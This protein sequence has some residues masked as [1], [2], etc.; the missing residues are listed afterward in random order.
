[1]YRMVRVQ[2]EKILKNTGYALSRNPQVIQTLKDNH[3]DQSL[4]KQMLFLSKK[5]NL[6]YIVLINLKGIRFTHPDSTKI[7]KPFQGGD[8]QAVFKGKAIMSTAEGSLGK[9]LRY[10]IPVYDHQKQVGAIAVGLKLTTLGDLSQSSIK[11]F[12]KPL[13]ISILIS[14]V[15]TSI[16]SYGLKKQLHN[17]HPSD[18]FQHLEERNATLDQIQAAVFVIDQRH[19][20]KRNNPAASL[21][22]KKEGQRDLF[23]GKLLES[24]IPQLKQDHFSKKTEQVLHF[25]GQDYLLSISPITVKTQNRGYVVFLR[26]VT[27]TLFTLDQL[28][29]T[30]A[31][32][33]ALQAQTHQFM[34]QLHVIYGLADIEYH[35]ELKIYLKEL[36]EPQNEFLARLSMLV[37]EPRLASFIIGER[38]KFAEKHINLSTEI[39]VDIPTKSTVEDVNNYLLLHRYINTKILT[40]LNSTTLVSLRLNYQNNLI[41]TDYQWENEKWLLNDYHQYFNDAYFQQLL[42]DSRATYKISLKQDKVIIRTNIIYSEGS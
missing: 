28:A 26:N 30:T 39:L 14:L 40:L 27:E 15:V 21:L 38:E 33:S 41:E 23:S 12:S 18:I 37:R 5:S 13:L 42:V 22:F 32:A 6:D 10:L 16:I 19:I 9:S 7:G 17:L 8:E 34:N 11:E 35:D 31:Y 25:Q 20:I 3:Y 36:L 1:T 2:E 24:L 4:Q 29:H